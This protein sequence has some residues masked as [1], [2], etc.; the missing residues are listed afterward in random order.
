M[1]EG[2]RIAMWGGGLVREVE[3]DELG[4]KECSAASNIGFE[5]S[6]DFKSIF[7]SKLPLVLL[8]VVPPPPPD[9]S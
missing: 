3:V 7:V 4:S 5:K 2:G 6:R 1:E 8:V 9:G